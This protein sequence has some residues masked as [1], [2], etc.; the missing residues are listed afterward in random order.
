M[1]DTDSNVV[2]VEWKEVLTDQLNNNFIFNSPKGKT[3]FA[4][5]AAFILGWL[6]DHPDDWQR[7]YDDLYSFTEDYMAESA[8]LMGQ[9]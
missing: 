2:W 3:A 4:C 1:S 5:G 9:V 8:R 6:R 7:L